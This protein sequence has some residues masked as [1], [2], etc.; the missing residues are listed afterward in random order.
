MVIE[1]GSDSVTFLGYIEVGNAGPVVWPPSGESLLILA[2]RFLAV[3]LVDRGRRFLI[4]L[5][6]V[7]VVF[8]GVCLADSFRVV[9]GALICYGCDSDDEI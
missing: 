6:S 3:V 9:S 1:V 8:L 2:V 7:S 5:L 4:G